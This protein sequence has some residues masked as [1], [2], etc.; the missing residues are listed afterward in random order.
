LWLTGPDPGSGLDQK[1]P[2][3]RRTN[4]AARATDLRFLPS[5]EDSRDEHLRLLADLVVEAY[6][7]HY[8]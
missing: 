7:Y 2:A 1:K 3:T 4:E 6:G 5:P 8:I